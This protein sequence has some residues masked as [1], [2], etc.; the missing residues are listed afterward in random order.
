MAIFANRNTDRPTTRTG[1]P[2][3]TTLL[4]GPGRTLRT[5]RR[6]AVLRTV[7]PPH[8]F[9]QASQLLVPGVGPFVHLGLG[10]QGR[11]QDVAVALQGNHAVGQD[12]ETF[13]ELVE[14]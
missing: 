7:L 3:R 5:S 2:R 8:L 12:G 9:G 11:E 10:F 6:L 4:A 1:D 14:F 13:V